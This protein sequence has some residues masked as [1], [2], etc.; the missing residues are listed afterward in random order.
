MGNRGQDCHWG[1][2][3]PLGPSQGVLKT[4]CGNNTDSGGGSPHSDSGGQGEDGGLSRDLCLRHLLLI[5]WTWGPT[6]HTWESESK[7]GSAK[8]TEKALGRLRG[9]MVNRQTRLP[10]GSRTKLDR[11]PGLERALAMNRHFGDSGSPARSGKSPCARALA[12][13]K[14]R[15]NLSASFQL[16]ELPLDPPPPPPVPG[17]FSVAVPGTRCTC[18][19]RDMSTG[20][21]SISFFAFLGKAPSNSFRGKQSR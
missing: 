4:Q 9:L 14:R 15:G 17:A 16:C 2:T 8:D 10:H 12:R 19:T 1:R 20:R 13:A 6:A 7:F 5:M 21:G 3:T 18:E 11:C